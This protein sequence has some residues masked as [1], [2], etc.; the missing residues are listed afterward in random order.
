[1]ANR[2]PAPRMRGS[3][4][5]GSSYPPMDAMEQEDDNGL[6]DEVSF[7]KFD[8]FFFDMYFLV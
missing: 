3:V 6:P 5:S 2:V 4:A 7:F 1:M 8:L